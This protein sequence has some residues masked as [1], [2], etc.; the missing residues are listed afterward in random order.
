MIKSDVK[1]GIMLLFISAGI[2]LL[3]YEDA[4]ECSLLNDTGFRFII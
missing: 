2:A 4:V 1:R 3:I